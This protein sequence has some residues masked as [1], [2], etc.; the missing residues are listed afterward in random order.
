MVTAPPIRF[1]TKDDNRSRRFNLM[2]T[3]IDLAFHPC[4]TRVCTVAEEATSSFGESELTG[5][6]ALSAS[7]IL[8][9]SKV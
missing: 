4:S 7:L 1:F 8:N 3:E 2:S 5:F 6:V 9:L